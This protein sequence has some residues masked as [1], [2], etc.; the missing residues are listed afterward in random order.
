MTVTQLWSDKKWLPYILFYLKRRY[1][2]LKASNFMYDIAIAVDVQKCSAIFEYV[3]YYN[4]IFYVCTKGSLFCFIVFSKVK[5]KSYSYLS[6][7]HPT[8]DYFHD[9][10]NPW[11]KNIQRLDRQVIPRLGV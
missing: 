10:E 8:M 11:K 3:L 1:N 5:N 9:K 2:W 4:S 6:R 7:E